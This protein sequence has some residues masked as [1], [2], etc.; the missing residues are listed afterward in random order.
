VGG[1]SIA[2]SRGNPDG[3]CERI[4]AQTFENRPWARETPVPSPK[5]E[6]GTL[7]RRW[8][9]SS[10]QRNGLRNSLEKPQQAHSETAWSAHPHDEV[11]LPLV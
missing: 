9:A 7:M 4:L 6:A 1:G 3:P 8:Y 10:W 5:S 11:G 2:S